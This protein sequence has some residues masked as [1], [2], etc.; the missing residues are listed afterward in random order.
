MLRLPGHLS[1]TSK[2]AKGHDKCCKS[3]EQNP[4]TLEKQ[5]EALQQY[6]CPTAVGL[7]VVA[8]PLP[9]TLCPSLSTVL[10]LSLS[11]D[12]S[13]LYT[14]L[15]RLL[16]IS[17]AACQVSSSSLIL[18]VSLCPLSLSVCLPVSPSSCSPFSCCQV[19]VREAFH[20]HA[21]P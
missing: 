21:A 13:A 4:R 18:P 6:L 7:K 2:R 10:T 14:T 8:V 5:D 20:V 17:S 3:H 12:T 19:H 16:A 9:R 15:L 11:L 1:E